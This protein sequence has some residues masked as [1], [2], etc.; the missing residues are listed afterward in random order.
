MKNIIIDD[1]IKTNSEISIFDNIIEQLKEKINNNV[2]YKN[3]IYLYFKTLYNKKSK[4]YDRLLIH[5]FYKKNQKNKHEYNFS[6]ILNDNYTYNIFPKVYCQS[7]YMN[8]DINLID[9]RDL[10]HSLI[11][12]KY[13]I[14]DNQNNDTININIIDLLLDIIIIKIPEFVRKIYFYDENKILIYYGKYYLNEIYNI[15]DFISNKKIYFYK[16]MTYKCEKSK[17]YS[18]INIKYIIVSDF[19]ILFF[20]L[21]NEKQKN[22]CKL[23]FIGEI[24][25]INNIERLD[26]D[27]INNINN[28]IIIDDNNNINISQDKISIDWLS[29]YDE[30]VEI[31]FIFSIINDKIE[32]E[33]NPDFID[34]VNKKQTFI[35]INYKLI[36]KEYNEYN[37]RDELNKL[38]DLS[39]LLEKK[40]KL[41]NKNDIYIKEINRIYQKIIDISTQINEKEIIN[42]YMDKIKKINNDDN[43]MKEKKYFHSFDK[44]DKYGKINYDK[45]DDNKNSVSHLIDLF[46]KLK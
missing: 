8:K 22:L 33:E 7:L 18:T 11:E 39:K 31:K 43:I 26:I 30:N 40:E 27:E 29:D 16:V 19:H 41:I 36:M 10:F 4:I 6:I 46:E 42:E 14:S 21:I 25:K 20:D 34:I 23:I 35:G 38:I 24:F 28:N 37:N 15:N 32:K 45:K 12:K 17:E 1:Y 9:R 13:S 5:S 2:I 3:N 44:N